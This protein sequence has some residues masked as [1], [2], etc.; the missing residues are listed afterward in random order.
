LSCPPVQTGIGSGSLADVPAGDDWVGLNRAFLQAGAS[1]VV[2]TLWSVE[3]WSTASFMDRFYREYSTGGD[4]VRALADAQRAA[5][6]D[7]QRLR[8][9]SP[10]LGSS[11]SAAPC[12]PVRATEED[13]RHAAS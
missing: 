3:D 6:G 10:G 9:P 11:S 12:T 13:F 1:R 2:A 4:P 7:I 8:I 5:L